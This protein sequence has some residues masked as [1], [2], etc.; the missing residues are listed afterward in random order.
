M[1]F[2]NNI[3]CVISSYKLQLLDEHTASGSLYKFI[4]LQQNRHSS[5]P[6]D[7]AILQENFV[8]SHILV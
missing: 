6:W 1:D 7:K 2:V 8:I 3:P 5:F 4:N